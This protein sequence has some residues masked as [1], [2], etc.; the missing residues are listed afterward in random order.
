MGL[1]KIVTPTYSLKIPSMNRMVKY[2]PFLVA[3]E[4]LLITALETGDEDTYVGA[5]KDVIERC[6]IDKVDINQLATFDIEYIMLSL[7]S[8]SRGEVVPMHFR[9]NGN[10]G[11]CDNKIAAL[12]N[13]NDVE[14]ETPVDHTN[15]IDLGGGVSVWM[16][17]P[18]HKEYSLMAKAMTNPAAAIDLVASCI[19]QY[20]SDGVV[21][22]ASSL[23]KDEIV[24]WLMG[25]LGVKFDKLFAFFSTMPK[26]KKTVEIKCN[27]C[28]SARTIVLEGI[29]DFF[30]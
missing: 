11:E 15:E 30:G 2:R 10:G 8:K 23:S 9:C 17:Y 29:E 14:V 5:I 13:L 12:V 20:S 21:E 25:L 3:E 6:L 1:P 18:T 26:L 27:K 4:K 24:N 22:E 28:G 19:E 7:R 16:R